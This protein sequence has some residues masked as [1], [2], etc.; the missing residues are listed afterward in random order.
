M[1]DG[2]KYAILDL[3]INDRS[4]DK[5]YMQYQTIHEKPLVTGH[6]SRLPREAFHFLD[7]VPLLRDLQ[8]R[9]QLPDP[10]L[11]A[12]GEQLRL[13]HEAGVRY[14]LIHKAFANAGP[15]GRVARLADFNPRLRR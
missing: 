13:L 1:Q 15:A 6:V 5:W 12:V 4:Y 8:Q 10:A 9:D 14:L 7:S 2:E 11:T 3:P